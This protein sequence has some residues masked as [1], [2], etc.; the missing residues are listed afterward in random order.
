MKHLE[1]KN[2]KRKR[3]I[4]GF[5]SIIVY[6]NIFCW[7]SGNNRTCVPPTQK[8]TTI[9]Q[10]SVRLIREL[11]A[12]PTKE[13]RRTKRP[14]FFP[15]PFFF[16]YEIL[17]S[18]AWE[19]GACRKKGEAREMREEA[20]TTFSSSSSSSSF[21]FFPRPFN[22]HLSKSGGGGGGGRKVTLEAASNWRSAL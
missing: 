11:I 15:S 2:Q 3:W 5:L 1:E 9:C 4:F 17:L 12:F 14:P 20:K 21:P 16:F 7:T 10:V 22:C 8:K 6:Y 18:I 19:I 13:K